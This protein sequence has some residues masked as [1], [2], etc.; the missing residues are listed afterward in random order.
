MKNLRTATKSLDRITDDVVQGKGT[1]GKLIVDSDLYLEVNAVMGKVNNL[2]KLISCLVGELLVVEA[3]IYF[4]SVVIICEHT[5]SGSFGL[6]INKPLEIEL[7]EELVNIDVIHFVLKI[8]A[9][10]CRGVEGIE[11]VDPL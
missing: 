10:L 2:M 7:P 11:F 9:E 5:S 6:I 3:G 1:L 8:G 4:R